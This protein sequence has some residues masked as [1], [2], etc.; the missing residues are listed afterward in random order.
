MQRIFQP[1][2]RV[3]RRIQHTRLATRT[4]LVSYAFCC[5]IF[6]ALGVFATTDLLLQGSHWGERVAIFL[7]GLLGEAVFTPLLGFA[8]FGFLTAQEFVRFLDEYRS[9]K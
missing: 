9:G 2:V 7:R 6:A 4:A 3:Y 8:F 1:F 5:A